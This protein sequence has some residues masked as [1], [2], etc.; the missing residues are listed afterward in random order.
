[1]STK[2]LRDQPFFW[3]GALGSLFLV[4]AKAADWTDAPW[5]WVTSPIWGPLALL[6]VAGWL[7]FARV[8]LR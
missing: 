3:A 1:M 6:L 8:M 5:L 2:R 7:G 4:S